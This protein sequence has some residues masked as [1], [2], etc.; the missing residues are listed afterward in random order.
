MSPPGNK[1]QLAQMM[2]HHL[3]QLVCARGWWGGRTRNKN[4]ERGFALLMVLWSMVLLSLMSAQILAS[5][6]GAVALAGNLR[7]AAEAQ[8]AADGA[9]YTAIYHL[10]S[11]GSSQWVP[12]GSQ[13]ALNVGGMAASVA[14]TSLG[15][16]INP[17]LASTALLTGLF[18]AVGA[19]PQQAA[20]LANAVIAWRAAPVSAAAGQLLQA[21][22]KQAGLAFGPPAH[23]FA[24]LGEMTA[25]IGMPPQ[26]LAAA[27][28]HMSI[29]QTGDPD[30]RLADPVVRRALALSGQ[31]GLDTSGYTGTSPV[32]LIS[33][34]AGLTGKLDVR[35][36]AIVS[37]S[38]QGGPSPYQLLSLTD[39]N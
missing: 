10:S 33:A 30:P 28:P 11:S 17:N 34:E 37:V 19:A 8:A 35:R 2:P 4:R 15:G 9:I 31:H 24:D 16:K 18:Q 13:H 26:L 39:Q 38:N 27:L 12:D 6:R 20:A 32:F 5:G 29:Y 14:V 36:Q 1:Y 25:L 22:Y 3:R 23:G 7:E 21:Q